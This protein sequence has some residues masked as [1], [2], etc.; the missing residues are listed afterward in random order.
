MRLLDLSARTHCRNE[1]D[2]IPGGAFDEIGRDLS[3]P[4]ERRLEEH[5]DRVVMRTALR[6]GPDDPRTNVRKD[7]TRPIGYLLGMRVLR[8]STSGPY[9]NG[10]GARSARAERPLPRSLASKSGLAGAFHVIK[11]NAACG[12][13]DWLLRN[14]PAA[15]L[16]HIV[17]HPGGYLASWRNRFLAS[18][19]EPTVHSRVRDRLEA[20]IGVEP[21]LGAIIGDPAT[22]TLAEAE[23]WFWRYCNE[24]LMKSGE[25]R[26]KYARVK[27][28]DLALDPVEVGKRTFEHCGLDWSDGVELRVRSRAGFAAGRVDA[29]RSE[30]SSEDLES[31]ARV[32]DGSPLAP[33]W[34]LVGT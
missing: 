4:S 20:L 13:G 11:V 28:E 24:K 31:V 27:F 10:K 29:W 30:L 8:R 25:G 14:R 3:F 22:A 23:L 15:H 33:L 12:L 5:W 21:D 16:L 32:L 19:D 34:G 18:R 9:L 6:F 26:K 1:P 17:R 2:R 7:W